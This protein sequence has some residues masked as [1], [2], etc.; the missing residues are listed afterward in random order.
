MR[1]LLLA[2]L[3]AV[4][5]LTAAGLSTAVAPASAQERNYFGPRGPAAEPERRTTVMPPVVQ[6]TVMAIARA[7]REL[8]ARLSAEIRAF[9]ESG[10][11]APAIAILVISF[12]YGLFH[13]VGPGHGKFITTSYF[14]ANRAR[15]AHGIAL[16]GLM[17][18]IQALSAIL[19]VTLFA[20]LLNVGSITLVNNVVWVEM[21]SYALIL[22]LGVYIVWGGIVGRGCSHGHG[23]GHGQDIARRPDGTGP[24]RRGIL[25]VAFAGGIRPCTGAILVLLFTL[26]QGIFIV[27]I[28]A[29]L[30]MA[31]G[32]AITISALGIAT[33]LARKGVARTANAGSP[34]ANIAHRA[35]GLVGGLVIVSVASLLL[36]GTLER[37]G[38][39][40]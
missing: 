14:L 15:L 3:L 33:I 5:G 2:L 40:A 39:L 34:T 37:T 17:S 7:Q 30:V 11:L 21:A 38:L 9:K 6:R 28:V 27:G 13:A 18:L 31:L 20:I 26:A 4:A 25:A 24:S 32:V 36:L 1:R 22:L 12:L 8:N 10:R 16:G 35:A 19:L 29:A 23:N